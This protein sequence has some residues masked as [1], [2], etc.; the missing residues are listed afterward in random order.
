MLS[1]SYSPPVIFAGR[2]LLELQKMIVEN[3]LYKLPV[4]RRG[5]HKPITDTAAPIITAAYNYK[6]T[7][8]KTNM[9]EA[10]VEIP[11]VPNLVDS[12]V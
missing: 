10:L 5:Y 1:V 7:N 2:N 4:Y 8:G 9:M 12:T 6:V 11:D 3:K